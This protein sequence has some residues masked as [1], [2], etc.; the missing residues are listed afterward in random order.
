MAII[1]NKNTTQQPLSSLGLTGTQ[2]LKFIDAPRVYLKT[3]DPLAVAI[4]PTAKSNGATPSGWT[5]LGVVEG[6]CK[7]GV[8]KKVKQV[9]TGIDNYLRA[10]YTDEKVGTF[11]FSLSQLDDIAFGQVT[12][13]TASVV[14][15][16]STYTYAVGSED[17]SQQAVL[18]VVQ[19]KLDG[20]E[21]QFYNPN[22]Y[23]NFSI[24][25]S[26]DEFK[27]KV[28]GLLPFF[29]APGQASEQMLAQTLFR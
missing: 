22:A 25:D 2:V 28:T 6:T 27:L 5:D 15:T 10:A 9:K 13:L 23:I 11:E 24:E 21:W 17:L 4:I 26:G 12:G 20:K 3:A 14:N 19:N 1:A 16:G 18:M 7:I 8:E 29:L